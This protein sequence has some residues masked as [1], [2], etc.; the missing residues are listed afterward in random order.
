MARPVVST[1]DSGRL[2]LAVWVALGAVNFVALALTAVCVLFGVAP[3]NPMLHGFLTELRIA[4]ATD[5]TLRVT[6]V[7]VPERGFARILLPAYTGRWPA[8]PADPP[9]DVVLEP[10]GEAV[11]VYDWDDCVL[12]E[13]IVRRASGALGTV[14]V[15]PPRPAGPA[16][17]ITSPQVGA[18]TIRSAEGLPPPA[19]HVVAPLLAAP[20]AAPALP[21]WFLLGPAVHAASLVALWRASR[22]RR[23]ARVPP[24]VPAPPAV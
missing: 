6:P 5:E 11:F 10:G 21:R 19:A 15:G 17:R 9:R 23:R 2:R 4:N 12:S 1:A 14:V 3:F 8:F 7:A 24:P 18:V 20:A 22:G 16:A 13:V